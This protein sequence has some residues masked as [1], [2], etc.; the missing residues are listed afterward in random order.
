M[1]VSAR[2][3]IPLW[4]R[5]PFWRYEAKTAAVHS[6]HIYV[7]P[8]KNLPFTGLN[9]FLLTGSALIFQSVSRVAR[10]IGVFAGCQE[11]GRM[12]H[13]DLIRSIKLLHILLTTCCAREK[14]PLKE[15]S[16][17]REPRRMAVSERASNLT[18]NTQSFF[19]WINIFNDTE[20]L[21]S[22]VKFSLLG[23]PD[24]ITQN[25]TLNLNHATIL[26]EKWEKVNKQA[27]LWLRKHLTNSHHWQAMHQS[28]W[29]RL[30]NIAADKLGPLLNITQLETIIC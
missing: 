7:S 29:W 12:N 8:L 2:G 24:A 16:S 13:P 26:Q 21:S 1:D 10:V 3:S 20:K 19:L 28:P 6:K 23:T 22:L 11:I 4:K 30:T 5:V 25:Q 27:T 15:K 14:K 18:R 17:N 9:L